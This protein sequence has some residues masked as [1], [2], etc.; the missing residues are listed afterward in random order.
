[1]DMLPESVEKT[2]I[3]MALSKETTNAYCVKRDEPL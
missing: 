2:I 1:M 3:L